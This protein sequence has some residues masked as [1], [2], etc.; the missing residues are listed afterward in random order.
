MVGP[1]ALRMLGDAYLELGD[2]EKAVSNY[3]EAA[4]KADNDF[5]TPEFLMRAGNTYEL[6]KDYKKALEAYTRIKKEYPQSFRSNNIEKYM[7]RAELL[8]EHGG[9]Q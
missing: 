5:L 1:T 2:H 3:L 7:A 6:K 8:L 9:D 4:K